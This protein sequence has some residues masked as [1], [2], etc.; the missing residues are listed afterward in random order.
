MD[1]RV[2]AGCTAT[3]HIPALRAGDVMENGKKIKRS[4]EI[5]YQGMEDGYAVYNVSS[6]NYIFKSPLQK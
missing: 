5:V 1:I 2:P 6:G 3:V 4:E